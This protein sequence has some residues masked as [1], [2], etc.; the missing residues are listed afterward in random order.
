MW[1]FIVIL[2]LT[3]PAYAIELKRNN[4]F[5]SIT[6]RPDWTLGKDLFGIP[7]VYFS[8]EQNGQ[9]S[10]ISFTDTEVEITL[11]TGD[12]KSTQETY[13]ANKQAWAN[14][15]KASHLSFIPYETFKN[16]QGHQVHKIGVNFEHEG[17]LY[18]EQSFYINC[19]KKIIFSK[20]IRLKQNESHDP[21]F[22]EFIQSLSCGEA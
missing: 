14:Q 18:V 5:I 19:N 6:E 15:V 22:L 9:R 11:N 12:L 2:I 10:N 7:F 17:K 21:I 3:L 8:P 13:Q 1:K 20:A 16:R 4:S